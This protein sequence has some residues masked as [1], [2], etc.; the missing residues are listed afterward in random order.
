MQNA[1]WAMIRYQSPVYPVATLIIAKKIS[2]ATAVT[3][4]GIIR[5][6]LIIANTTE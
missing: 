2:K 6:W 5:G 1:E 3:I 4:S